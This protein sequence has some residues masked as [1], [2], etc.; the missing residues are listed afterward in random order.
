MTCERMRIVRIILCV[1]ASTFLISITLVIP[2]ACNQGAIST[3]APD[4]GKLGHEMKGWELYSWQEANQWNFTLIP[5]TNRNKE[6]D[7]IIPGGTAGGEVKSLSAYT[8]HVAGVDEI[9]KVL[10]RLP[11]GE[12]VFW[13]S[14]F[15]FGTESRTDPRLTLPPQNIIDAIKEQARQSGLDL[16]V[17]SA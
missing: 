12:Y 16:Y 6:I 13:A 15:P 14:R 10:S 11:P 8:V 1:L 7:E 5:G 3:S 9:R 4:A 2:I 17:N